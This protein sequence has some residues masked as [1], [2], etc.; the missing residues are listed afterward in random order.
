MSKN[1]EE[2]LRRG[3]EIDGWQL[4]TEYRG[5]EPI[6]YRY[7]PDWVAMQLYMEGGYRTPEEAKLRWLEYW[8]RE[9][10]K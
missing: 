5:G 9:V 6:A 4:Y 8:E 3:E 7:G 10:R 1:Y 2:I